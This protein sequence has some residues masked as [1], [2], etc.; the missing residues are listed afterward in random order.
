MLMLLLIKNMVSHSISQLQI[1]LVVVVSTNM[2]Q[3]G[4]K[5]KYSNSHLDTGHNKRI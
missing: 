4:S 5:E 3:V 2:G 1:D